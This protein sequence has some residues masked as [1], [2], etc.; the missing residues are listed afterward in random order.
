[1]LVTVVKIAKVKMDE[2]GN[3]LGLDRVQPGGYLQIDGQNVVRRIIYSPATSPLKSQQGNEVEIRRPVAAWSGLTYLIVWPPPLDMIG[4]I[5]TVRSTEISWIVSVTFI[6]PDII[7][8]T[9]EVKTAPAEMAREGP[10]VADWLTR[11]HRSS[12]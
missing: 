1:M 2:S 3:I 6:A 12:Q 11:L 8:L 9:L 7:A 5:P 10:L 4:S